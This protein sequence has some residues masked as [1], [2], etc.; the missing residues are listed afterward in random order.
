MF[1]L[2]ATSLT[3]RGG[4]AGNNISGCCLM[5]NFPGFGTG[6]TDFKVLIPISCLKFKVSEAFSW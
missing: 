3:T 2:F 1:A 4:A 5:I 6:L